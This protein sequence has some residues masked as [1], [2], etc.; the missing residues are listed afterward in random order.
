MEFPIETRF[1]SWDS[2]CWPTTKL[3]GFSKAEVPVQQK[4]MQSLV[5]HEL[6]LKID[7]KR[8]KRKEAKTVTM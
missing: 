7:S 4:A 3:G 6:D 2:A 5:C 8:N 1:I